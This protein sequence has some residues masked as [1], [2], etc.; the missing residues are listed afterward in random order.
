MRSAGVRSSTHERLLQCSGEENLFEHVVIDWRR[1]RPEIVR[2]NR[3]TLVTPAY[4]LALRPKYP[5][6][7]PVERVTKL[8]DGWW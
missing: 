4:N 7:P 1:F 8:R 6:S 2:L 3:L 5:S